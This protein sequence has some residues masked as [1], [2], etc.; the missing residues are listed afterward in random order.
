MPL[1]FLALRG[2]P[3]IPNNAFKSQGVSESPSASVIRPSQELQTM[4]SEFVANIH[5]AA[6]IAARL[7]CRAPDS[8]D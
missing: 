5:K 6:E 1:S 4:E 7:I 8:I 2:S 3:K